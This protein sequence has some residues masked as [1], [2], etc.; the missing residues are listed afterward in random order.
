MSRFKAEQTAY[1][2]YERLKPQL[3]MEPGAKKKRAIQK[4]RAFCKRVETEVNCEEVKKPTAKKKTKTVAECLQLMANPE[5]VFDVVQDVEFLSHSSEK[6]KGATEIFEEM[7]VGP[8]KKYFPEYKGE[9]GDLTACFAEQASQ[10][11]GHGQPAMAKFLALMFF[12]TDRMFGKSGQWLAAVL[13]VNK[14]SS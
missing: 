5:R 7:M 2:E 11:W 4:I 14:S 13:R 10:Q 8:L 1:R 12:C 9:W 6:Q 3:S